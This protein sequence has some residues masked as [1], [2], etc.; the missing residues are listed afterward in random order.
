M[1][2]LLVALPTP[3][4]EFAQSQ[5]NELGFRDVSAYLEGLINADRQTRDQLER[6]VDDNR[7]KLES[8]VIEGLESG[9]AGPMTSEDWDRL[10]RPFLERLADSEDQ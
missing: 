8:L 4:I 9:D 3:L 6:F 7:E 10:K 1:N 2:E 5:A